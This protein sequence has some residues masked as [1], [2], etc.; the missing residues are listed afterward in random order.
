V[1]STSGAWVCSDGSPGC[2]TPPPNWTWQECT[3]GSHCTNTGDWACNPTSPI[4]IDTRGEGFHLTDVTHGVKFS[5]LPGEPAVQTSWTDPAF[6]NGFLVLDRN[7]DGVINDGTE[8]FGN[9]TLQPPSAT[10]NG[11]L[12]LAVF[13][14]PANGGNGNGFIDPGDAIYDKLRVWI[15]V[16]HNGISEPGELH[17]LREL[18]IVRID[19][20]YRLSQ[21]VDQFGNRFRYAARIWDEA[22]KAHDICYDVFL[23]TGA[24][25]TTQ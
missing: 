14:D 12:A 21:Y 4:I 19:L 15:D 25:S 5:F 22:G 24:T 3:T 18:G 8:L 1:C 17:T 16:N 13:D 20:K 10:P 9:L 2:F 7:G 6:S 11:Y 23:R